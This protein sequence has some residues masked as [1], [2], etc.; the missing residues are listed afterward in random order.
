MDN[1]T[2]TFCKEEKPF[3]LFHKKESGRPKSNCIVCE[4]QR[5]R[6]RRKKKAKEAL[7]KFLTE[8][9]ISKLWA[10]REITV[11]EKDIRKQLAHMETAFKKSKDET[12][13]IQLRWK[14]LSLINVLQE[15]LQTL[16]NFYSAMCSRADKKDPLTYN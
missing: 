16:P 3:S 9:E 10:K 11:W 5:A 8:K 14:F 12:E 6:D 15:H 2:C 7:T 13:R 1:K 4:N